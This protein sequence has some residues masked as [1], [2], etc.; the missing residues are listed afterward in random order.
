M[1]DEANNGTTLDL[2]VRSNLVGLRVDRAISLLSGLT[3]S[4]VRSLIDSGAV[5]VDG[6]LIE[7]SSVTLSEG[8]HLVVQLP[9]D[10]D[11]FI[12]PESDVAIDVVALDD[13]FVVVNKS[14][15]VVVHPGAGQRTGTLVAGVLARFPEIQ[16]LVDR[17]ICEPLR[18]GV[19][20]RL[21]KGTSGLMVFAR[22]EVGYDSLSEQIGARSMQRTYL[23]L[24]Q[25][26]VK[27]E[28]GLIDAPIG[29]STR[30][31]TL[32]T[33]RKGG[34]EARTNYRV[35]ERLESPYASTLLELQ[36]DTGRTHQIRV[37]LAA[38]GHP[39]VN[40]TRYGHFRDRRLEADRHFLHSTRLKF[41]HPVSSQ[42][43][44]SSAALPK[45]LAELFDEA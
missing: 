20:H 33:V 2:V 18:P 23:A 25:G 1:T 28:R 37:H 21:D 29:R 31:P 34:R 8:Q 40:D 45:D 4:V 32:M 43:V 5:N 14:P 35:L 19:V 3:R 15:G 38:L 12:T 30:Q 16:D 22:T 17:E 41:V 39:V 10:E 44:V 24:V 13:S 42:D 27:N 36:L 26:H 9:S 7:K 11:S 6:R